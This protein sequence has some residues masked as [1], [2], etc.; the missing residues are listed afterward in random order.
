MAPLPNDGWPTVI[1]GATAA[2]A[3]AAVVAMYATMAIPS[4]PEVHRGLRSVQR[5][6]TLDRA[7]WGKLHLGSLGRAGCLR[8]ASG[9]VTP[10][11]PI[12]RQLRAWGVVVTP[13]EN[14]APR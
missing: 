5:A 11:S 12:D 2:R 14:S 10:G 8:A 6:E 4:W 7:A 3:I 9:A 1:R 13:A